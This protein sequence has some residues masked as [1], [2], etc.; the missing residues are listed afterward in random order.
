MTKQIVAAVAAGLAVLSGTALAQTA[1]PMAHKTAHK[2]M[3]KKTAA[4]KGVYVCRE[5][6]E[7]FSAAQAKKMNYKDSMGHALTKTAKAPA[8]FTDGAKSSM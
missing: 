5:C 2:A 6:R 1:K 4:A 3:A 7:Y 8:G